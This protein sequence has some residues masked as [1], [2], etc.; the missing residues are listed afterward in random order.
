MPDIKIVEQQGK[1]GVLVSG[2]VLTGKEAF[3]GK[4]D[5][6]DDDDHGYM[7]KLHEPTQ[8]WALEPTN[9]AIVT[10]KN[11]YGS[12]SGFYMV[13]REGKTGL[14]FI[15]ELPIEHNRFTVPFEGAPNFRMNF[16][17][18]GRTLNDKWVTVGSYVHPPTHSQ[19]RLESDDNGCYHLTVDGKHGLIAT[20]ASLKKPTYDN[21]QKICGQ[22]YLF[23]TG[24]T[25]ELV[26]FQKQAARWVYESKIATKDFDKMAKVIARVRG[27]HGNVEELAEAFGAKNDK[28]HWWQ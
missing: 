20:D 7:K 28:K 23:K 9:D 14:Y 3:H 27:F 25:Y 8:K 2:E 18:E 10:V 4:E 12:D 17:S 11:E 22:T 6:W 5:P 15:K 1:Y 13:T 26:A 19:L 21:L 24:K 16:Y